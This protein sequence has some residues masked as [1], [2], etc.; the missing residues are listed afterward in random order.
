MCLIFK[1]GINISRLRNATLPN[2]I[3]SAKKIAPLNTINVAITDMAFNTSFTYLGLFLFAENC[4]NT[5]TASS[6]VLT[7]NETILAVKLSTIFLSCALF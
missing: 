2:N 6:G 1:R 7:F 3:F 5:L 4:C